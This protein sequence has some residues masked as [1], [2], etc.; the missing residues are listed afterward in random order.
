MHERTF[1][2]D[3]GHEQIGRFWYALAAATQVRSA[4][5]ERAILSPRWLAFGKTRWPLLQAGT[6]E[7]DGQLSVA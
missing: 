6:A 5:P 1:M 2:A 7:P 3:C 4:R